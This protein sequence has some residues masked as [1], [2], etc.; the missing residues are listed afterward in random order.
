MIALDARKF[1]ILQTIVTDYIETAEPVGSRTIAKKYDIGVSS[2][3]IRNEMSDLE[4][5][6]LICQLHTSSGRVPSEKGY[7]YYVDRMMERRM[8]TPDEAMFLQGMI[9][10]NIART[11]TL[12]RTTAKA[13]SRLTNC[14]AVVSEPKMKKTKIKHIQLVPLD[15]KN[16]LIVLVTDRKTVKSHVL[17]LPAAPG[18]EALTRLSAHMNASLAGLAVREI[19]R[20]TIERLLG[21]FGGDA[22]ALMPALGAIADMLGQEDD[23][24]VHTSG[25]KNILAFPEFSDIRKAEAIVNAFEDRQFLVELLAGP[26]EVQILIGSENSIE[27]LKACSLIKSDFA[28]DSQS[29]GRIAIVGPMR[30]DYSQAVSALCGIVQSMQAVV[31]ALGLTDSGKE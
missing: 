30:M 12:A 19:G 23:V 16:M 25:V 21:L 28:I 18:Y 5:M 13:L 9:M 8:L 17:A 1:K 31:D 2:A 14:P 7:R 4:D 26:G 20:G 22:H 29:S 6:G 11:E 24:R 3:T 15:D 27:M 10:D